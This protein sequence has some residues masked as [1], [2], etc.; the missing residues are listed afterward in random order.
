MRIFGKS[1]KVMANNA[2]AAVISGDIIG[3]SLL[4]QASR[5]K[6]QQLLKSFFTFTKHE[7]SDMQAEQ[8]RGDSIQITLTGNRLAALR[9][10]LLLHTCLLKDKF[11]IRLAIGVGEIN[12]QSG[13]VVTSDGSAFQAS[14]P[15]LDELTKSGELISIASFDDDF[16]SE[17]QVHSSSLNFIL[18]RLTQ[19]QAEAVYLQLQDHTQAAIAKKL[20]IKQPSVH[21]RLQAAG[22]PVVQKILTRFESVIPTV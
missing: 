19:Q 13:Q 5:K 8:Y 14:G 9:I 1:R 16:T 6:L 3:S 12:F 18:Q 22:W 4:K 11:K 7:W 2:K 20:K 17:W 15:Y 21:Q 10:A